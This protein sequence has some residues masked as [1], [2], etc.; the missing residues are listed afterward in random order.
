MGVLRV[1]VKN[2]QLYVNKQA[3]ACNI[4]TNVDNGALQLHESAWDTVTSVDD[5]A[6]QQH[7]G[8]RDTVTRVCIV[9]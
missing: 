9:L 5:G 4:S 8:A 6:L 2:P 7:G 3:Q 1:Q